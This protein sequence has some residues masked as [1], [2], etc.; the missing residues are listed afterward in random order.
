MCGNLPHP[1]SSLAH[2][3]RPGEHTASPLREGTA[4]A[5]LYMRRAK[6]KVTVCPRLPWGP[7][8]YH[9]SNLINSTSLHSQK[10]REM[11]KMCL[12]HPATSESKK[13]IQDDQGS[14]KRNSGASMKRLPLAKSKMTGA[15]V[16]TITAVDWS[17][18]VNAFSLKNNHHFYGK[19]NTQISTVKTSR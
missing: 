19:Q 9:C 8:L 7:S 10:G 2:T 18:P 3:A 1:Q 17:K 14:V 13:P 15:S 6:Y 12:E 11:Y 4:D 5:Q 16:R